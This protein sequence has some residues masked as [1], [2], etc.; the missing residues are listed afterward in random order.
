MRELEELSLNTWPAL[1]TVLMD[2]WVLRLSAGYTRRANSV[3]PL[4]PGRLP[5][6]EKI[7][8]AEALYT[9]CGL[10]VVFKLT[11]AAQPP[12]LDACLGALGYSRA[13]ATSVQ[14]MA[15]SAAAPATPGSAHV[16]ETLTEA[17]LD[18]FCALS[19][20]PTH[21]R[22][23]MQ[24]MLNSL[25]PAHGFFVQR[26]AQ[27]LALA[28]GLAVVERGHVGLADIVTHPAHRRQGH[29]QRLISD[30]L[31]WARTHSAHTAY[32]QVMQ[33]NAPALRLYAGLGYREVYEYWYRVKGRTPRVKAEGPAPAV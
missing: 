9:G 19:Q 26:D 33:N 30:M 7:E 25:V 23:T 27:G 11:P 21:H 4:Y 5:L 3:N 6:A 13:A 14:T 31:A 8:A 15:L 29:A 24:R 17:W 22:P 18:A 28:I 10:P 1:Q 32:L 12:E 20:A 2:G 16:D